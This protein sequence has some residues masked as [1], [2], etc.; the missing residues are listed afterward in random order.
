VGV[1][2]LSGAQVEAHRSIARLGPDALDA[3]TDLGEARRRLDARAAQEIG[4]ALLDQA[5]LAGVGNV[6]RCEVL[7]I[8]HIDPWTL[9][10]D[11][12]DA[13]RDAVLATAERL[14]K[15]NVARGSSARITTTTDGGGRRS[16]RD[17]L[18]VYGKGARPCPR[19]GT[20]IS[21]SRQGPQARHVFWC[22]TCQGPGRP[23]PA[24]SG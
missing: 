8:Q 13:Q 3:H 12:D 17:S 4:V 20:A 23:L 14:L 9:V 1:E 10:G 11:L 18:H 15:A 16:G 7:F 21:V 24:H 2:L 22:T 19:C 5:V 6:Y